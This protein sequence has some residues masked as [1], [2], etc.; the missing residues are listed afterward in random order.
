M[1]K[2]NYYFFRAKI[3]GELE[4]GIIETELSPKQAFE[5]LQDEICFKHRV[6]R[7]GVFIEKFELMPYNQKLN[8]TLK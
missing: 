4:S 1:N 6:N 5:S 8:P 7:G 3:G 2:I